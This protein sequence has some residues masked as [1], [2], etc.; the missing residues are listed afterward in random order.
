V[1]L[2]FM[3][4]RNSLFVAVAIPLS[5]LLAML[6]I[7]AFGMTLNM[8]VLFALILA[9]GMLVDNAI[10]LVENIYRHVEEGQDLRT[11]AVDGTK[12]VAG[13]VAASTATTVAAFAPLVFW[14]G[15]M[16][17]F[18]GFMPKTVIIVL[19]ARWCGRLRAPRAHVAG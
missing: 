1:I 17:Q 4:V 9:L 3:G 19:S 13:A 16:G 5:M 10:V 14:T 6:F 11:A 12:E 15:I 18:M 2:F 8:I 7:A